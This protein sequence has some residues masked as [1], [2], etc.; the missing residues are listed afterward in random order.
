M[1]DPTLLYLVSTDAGRWY[2]GKE[3]SARYSQNVFA[4][5]KQA[6]QVPQETESLTHM[7]LG[8]LRN[9]DFDLDRETNLEWY[10]IKYCRSSKRCW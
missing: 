3:A 6:I 1:L 2:L 5:R 7:I 8:T 9:S 10:K 4:E